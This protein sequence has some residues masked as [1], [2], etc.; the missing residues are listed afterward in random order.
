MWALSNHTPYKTER[1]FVRDVD[2]T[3]IWIVVVRGTFT[4][5]RGHPIQ[6]AEQQDEVRSVPEYIGMPG[7]SSLRYDTDLV[8]VKPGTDVLVHG[9]AYA[10]QGRAVPFVDVSLALGGLRKQIR[11]LGPRTWRRTPQGLVPET[12]RRFEVCDIVYEKAFGG[13]QFEPGCT[14]LAFDARNP[15]GCGLYAQEG[16]FAPN[17]EYPD[18]PIRS[19]APNNKPAGLGPI[20]CTW[21]PRAAFAGTFDEEWKSQRQPL[22]P[23]DFNDLYYQCA[24]ADQRI[25]GYVRG[26]EEVVLHNLTPGGALQF[27]MPDI[28]LGFTTRFNQGVKHHRSQIHTV[29]IEPEK[30]RLIVVWQTAL[31]CHHTLY[32]LRETI[33]FEKARLTL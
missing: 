17:I 3:E 26:G 20:P 33:V 5:R 29:I 21:M 32:S 1:V 31:P 27:R 10:P 12:P 13:T 7:R 18:A 8:R 14:P 15:V 23:R 24:P 11:V 16:Q 22:L 4:F 28:V 6:L 25:D 19:P 9:R 2:G 30:E